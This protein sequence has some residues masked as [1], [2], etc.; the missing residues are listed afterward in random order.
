MDEIGL[1]VGLVFILILLLKIGYWFSK[2]KFTNKFH[3][4]LFT[5]LIALVSFIICWAITG[6]IIIYF[7]Y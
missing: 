2:K 1:F 6:A 5:I 3:I 7:M 4:F